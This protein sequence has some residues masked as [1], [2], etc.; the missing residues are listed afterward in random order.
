MGLIKEDSCLRKIIYF[1]KKENIFSASNHGFT[2][3]ATEM[4]ALEGLQGD[5]AKRTKL[6]IFQ[7]CPLSII[8]AST[9]TYILLLCPS[10]KKTEKPLYLIR[11]QISPLLQCLH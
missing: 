3:T 1:V 6:A 10:K 8:L 7:N 5:L 2:T 9:T 4:G 11:A